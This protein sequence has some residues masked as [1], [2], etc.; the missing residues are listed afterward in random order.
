VRW[1]KTTP[2][3][4]GEQFG[5]TSPWRAEKRDSESL[6]VRKKGPFVE[7]DK[8]RGGRCE[9]GKGRLLVTLKSRQLYGGETSE[10]GRK[11][12]FFLDLC[13]PGD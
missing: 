6:A 7:P 2:G 13:G 11:L 3:G 12:K 5:I 9:E 1:K 4:R 10:G 8:R